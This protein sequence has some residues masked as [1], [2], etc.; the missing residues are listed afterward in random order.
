MLAAQF[1]TAAASARNFSALDEISRTLWQAHAAGAISD[2]AAQAAAEAVEA[3]RRLLRGPKARITGK[4]HQHPPQA[5]LARQGQVYRPPPRRRRVRR[6]AE[7]DRRIL[8]LGGSRRL[9]DHCRRGK[10]PRQVRTMP[11]QYRGSGRCLSQNSANRHPRSAAIRSSRHLRTPTPQA[12]KS[13][14]CRGNCRNGMA[15]LAQE[16]E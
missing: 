16:R 7:Q 10:A 6:C 11:R 5:S 13:A 14:E 2:D 15:L 1:A 12:E 9:V 3:R 4:T 8:H